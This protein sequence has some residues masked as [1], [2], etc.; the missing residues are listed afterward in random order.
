MFRL[1][2]DKYDFSEWDNFGYAKKESILNFDY[3]YADCLIEKGIVIIKEQSTIENTDNIFKDKI[4]GRTSDS[5]HF[6]C[7]K[8]FRNS[9]IS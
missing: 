5:K 8:N 7:V 4:F 3:T 6:I 2:N 9:R 1:V